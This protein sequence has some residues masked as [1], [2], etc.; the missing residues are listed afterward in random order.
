[1]HNLKE[2]ITKFLCSYL[3][4]RG[5]KCTALYFVYYMYILK[6]KKSQRISQSGA[7]NLA[8]T[9]SDFYDSHGDKEIQMQG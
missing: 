5:L 3:G 1:M 2:G 6:H 8:Y 9:F 7:A 4:Y